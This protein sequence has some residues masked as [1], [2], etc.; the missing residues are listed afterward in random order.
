MLGFFRFTTRQAGR[1]L[2]KF[3]DDFLG[4]NDAIALC[5]R[6]LVFPVSHHRNGVDVLFAK[7]Q[8]SVVLPFEFMLHELRSGDHVFSDNDPWVGF[9]SSEFEEFSSYHGLIR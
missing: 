3:C 4:E 9:E 5:R 1:S 2:I 7:W 8:D 6:P